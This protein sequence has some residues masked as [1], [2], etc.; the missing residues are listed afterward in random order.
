MHRFIQ[1]FKQLPCV[2]DY[3]PV[4]IVSYALITLH[5]IIL[6]IYHEVLDNAEWLSSNSILLAALKRLSELVKLLCY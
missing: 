1:L 2:L 3:N 4:C 5:Y 6:M